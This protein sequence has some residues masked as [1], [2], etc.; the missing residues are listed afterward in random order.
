MGVKGGGAKPA[1]QTGA[2]AVLPDW[3][4]GPG[5]VLAI[6]VAYACIH[7]LL[8][9]SASLN[10]PQD[11]V[12]AVLYS[13]TLQ[14]GYV[15][16]QPPL[17]DWLLWAVQQ[18][19]GPSLFSFL[20]LKYA[21]LTATGFFIYLA[22]L[23]MFRDSGWAA[24]AAFSLLLFYQIGWNIHEG[25]THTATM[26]CAIAA[27][28]WALIRLVETAGW[29]DYLV[30]GVCL[31]LG[32]LTKYGYVAFLVLLLALA[33]LQPVMRAKILAPRM[34]ASLAIAAL[35]ITPFALWIILNNHDLR[36]IYNE[37]LSASETGRWRGG[38]YAVFLTLR[39][40]LIFL[41]PLV[42]L[43][44][45][46][47]SGALAAMGQAI[48][49]MLRPT[50]EPDWE[51]IVVQ[52][53]FVALILML[54]GVLFT[55][56]SNFRMRYMHP[57]YLLMPLW[58]VAMARRGQTRKWQ[59]AAFVAASLFFALVVL[60][61]RAGYL[62][63]GEKPFCSKCRQMTPY[64]ELADAMRKQG[65]KTGTIVAAYRHTAGNMRRLFPTARVVALKWPRVVPPIRP[66]DRSAQI[67]LV[68]NVDSQGAALPK[69]AAD[70]VRALGGDLV[71]GS[72]Q[73]VR[74]PWTHLWRPTGYRSS[75]WNVVVIDLSRD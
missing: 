48:A 40:T 26:I 59:P 41:S 7:I 45:L 70:E 2:K 55:G 21:L 38:A 18:A 74:V 22:G 1:N 4:S 49:G 65:F 44:P 42:V 50:V 51:R 60:G 46:I 8:R 43:V 62:Y 34:L 32:G 47:F 16:R 72:P 52:I 11:D 14:L 10:L 54:L 27:T 6:F 20:L 58:L 23:R 68:W 13:H 69:G 57:F 5:G 31:G 61:A 3:A 15:P 56:A 35:I 53:A 24:L 73:S 71:D 37:T 33:L 30:F 66:G 19:A 75:H 36:A 17:Y 63:V 67:A 64:A 9:L 12:M 28:F 29:R 25:V 39:R